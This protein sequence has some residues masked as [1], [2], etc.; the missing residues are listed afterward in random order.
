MNNGDYK[1][2]TRYMIMH[3]YPKIYVYCYVRALYIIGSYNP[4]LHRW[5]KITA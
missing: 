3:F 4:P 5:H 2:M 1:Y